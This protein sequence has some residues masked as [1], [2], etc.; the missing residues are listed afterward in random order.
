MFPYAAPH[1]HTHSPCP[2]SEVDAML[3]SLQQAI[4]LSA[5]YFKIWGLVEA[6]CHVRVSSLHTYGGEKLF[7][8]ATSV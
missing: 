7:F 8:P 5:E 1:T 3:L 6:S 4:V 2:D